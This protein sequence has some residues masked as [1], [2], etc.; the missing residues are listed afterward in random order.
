VIRIAV[1]HV[2]ENPTNMPCTLS[3]PVHIRPVYASCGRSPYV[4]TF[5]ESSTEL[6]GCTAP[7]KKCSRLHLSASRVVRGTHLSFSPNTAIEVVR[8]SQAPVGGRLPCL[9]GPYHQHAIGTFNTCSRV[10]T[11]LSL[12]DT[13]GVYHIENLGIATTLSPPFPSE[14]STDPPNG[15]TQSQIIQQHLP[16]ELEGE[17][18]P[19]SREWE[20][21]LDFYRHLPSTHSMS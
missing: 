2:G 10:P 20:P 9:P 13:G 12:T 3:M 17:T 1:H 16:K 19:K 7:E 8:L 21:P 5:R 18:S 11:P 4:A 14:G 15:P 6:N